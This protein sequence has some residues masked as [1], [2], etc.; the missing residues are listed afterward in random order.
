M[1][2]LDEKLRQQIEQILLGILPFSLPKTTS[3][4]FKIHY[5]GSRKET[6]FAEWLDFLIP[7][8]EHEEEA[9]QKRCW[10]AIL[11]WLP[12][13][14]RRWYLELLAN[15]QL[16]IRHKEK[17]LAEIANLARIPVEDCYQIFSA[18]LWKEAAQPKEA[19]LNMI[20]IFMKQKSWRGVGSEIKCSFALTFGGLPFEW[21]NE[22]EAENI[23]LKLSKFFP[24]SALNFANYFP[25]D[26]AN[27]KWR[28]WAI[29]RLRE[30]ISRLSNQHIDEWDYRKI[31]MLPADVKKIF[32]DKQVELARSRE[33]RE[34]AKRIREYKK[35]D[36]ANV[37]ATIEN[38]L[39]HAQKLR[40]FT[41]SHPDIHHKRSWRKLWLEIGLEGLSD[42]QSSVHRL[43]YYLKTDKPLPNYKVFGDIYAEVYNH[44]QK[45]FSQEEIDFFARLQTNLFKVETY[46]KGLRDQETERQRKTEE[47]KET[48]QKQQQDKQAEHERLFQYWQNLIEQRC[49]QIVNIF[50]GL[51]DADISPDAVLAGEVSGFFASIQSSGSS[52]P[53]LGQSL[54]L[55]QSLTLRQCLN[56][57]IQTHLTLEEGD[58]EKEWKATYR[59]ANFLVWHELCH[60][61]GTSLVDPLVQQALGHA[62]DYS[63]SIDAQAR[64]VVIDALAMR[65]GEIFYVHPNKK[66]VVATTA[67]RRNIMLNSHL[68]AVRRVIRWYSKKTRE[69]GDDV[70]LSRLGSELNIH[71]LSL[72]KTEFNSLRESLKRLHIDKPTFSFDKLYQSALECDPQTAPIRQ[73]LSDP[74]IEEDQNQFNEPHL[75]LVETG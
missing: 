45:Q 53:S 32:T 19:F 72:N 20:A 28:N 62:P 7:F 4:S 65:F 8:L 10:Q 54:R 40:E 26:V 59:S 23:R 63:K 58:D 16:P 57:D 49:R 18:K 61:V 3:P 69:E 1:K 12:E 33:N 42:R 13:V 5:M 75:R 14:G 27:T 50:N 60:L 24:D 73:D 38:C 41:N 36:Q 29:Q 25:W 44:L 52:Y 48:K 6:V 46:F 31:E 30:A 67:Q 68:A 35:R 39:D 47:R 56:L 66:R 37:Q 55:S 70:F 15:P 74:D 34:T 9:V 22:D 17:L 43:L 64:E 21:K 71:L 11:G 2:Y 51:F